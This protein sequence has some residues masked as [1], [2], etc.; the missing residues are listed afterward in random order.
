MKALIKR[1]LGL[2]AHDEQDLLGEF[3][4]SEGG[5]VELWRC[6]ECYMVQGYWL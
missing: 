2:C 3:R 5:V 4:S 6:H 1:W